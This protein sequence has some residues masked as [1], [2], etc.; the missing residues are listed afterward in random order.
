MTPTRVRVNVRLPP[1]LVKW[2]KA[3][4]KKKK[5]SFT[6]VLEQAIGALRDQSD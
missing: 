1:D 5:M 3:Y 6:E 2:A 4:A